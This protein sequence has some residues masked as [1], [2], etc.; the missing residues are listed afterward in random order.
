MT[1]CN[2]CSSGLHSCNTV[3][4]A[5]M[6]VHLPRHVYNVALEE[7][8]LLQAYRTLC[9]VYVGHQCPPVTTMSCRNDIMTLA[10]QHLEPSSYAAL[11][12]YADMLSMKLSDAV[13]TEF[14]VPVGDHNVKASEAEQLA[15][16]HLAEG[17]GSIWASTRMVVPLLPFDRDTRKFSRGFICTLGL[18]AKRGTHGLTRHTGGHPN[19]C[20]LLN[21]LVRAIRPSLRWSSLTL[22]LDNACQPHMDAG[23]WTG[24]SLAIGLSHHDAGG[25]WIASAEGRDFVEVGETLYAGEVFPTSAQ[26]VLFAGKNTLHSTC[27]W[28]GGNRFMLIAYCVA[29]YASAPAELVQQAK[30][31]GFVLP[32]C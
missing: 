31:L 10:K 20:R 22:T 26:G 13:V 3:A 1:V 21:Q 9:G 30:E 2:M 15:W 29:G 4:T 5:S 23:N 18:M 8:L 19:V 6:Q 25:L 28:T 27:P 14:P 24:D 7:T 32:G 12:Q 16:H 11:S 17:S